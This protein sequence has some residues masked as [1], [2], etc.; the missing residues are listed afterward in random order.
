MAVVVFCKGRRGME[1]RVEIKIDSE[2]KHSVIASL[3]RFGL[4]RH[5]NIGSVRLYE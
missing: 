5:K 3:P 4:M 1:S 2:V